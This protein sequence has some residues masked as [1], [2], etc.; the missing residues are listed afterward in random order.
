VIQNRLFPVLGGAC[1]ILFSVGLF[2]ASSERMLVLAMAAIVSFIPFLGYLCSV[3]REAEGEHGW[4]AS[5]ALASGL[6]GITLKLAS[7]AP[8]IAIRRGDAHA[9]PVHTAIQ[10]IADTRRS[11]ACGPWPR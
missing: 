8:E 4:L 7:V 9:G 6:A 2:V 3:L 10:G 5:A 1:G 11:P